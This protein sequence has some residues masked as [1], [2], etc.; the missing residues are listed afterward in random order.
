MIIL[1]AID[2]HDGSCVRLMQGDYATAQKVAESP[3]KAASYFE[4]EGAHW[5][6]MVDLDGAKFGRPVNDSC[7][8]DVL[9]QVNMKVELGGG[10]RDMQTVE[11]YLEKGV[12]RIILG[13]V[14]LKDPAFVREA[15]RKY[16][17]RIAVGI[18]AKGGK[19]AAEGWLQVSDVD[20]LDLAREMEQIGV[21]YIIFTDISKDGTMNGPDL[22]M[23]DRINREVSCNI[24][25]SGGVSN[26]KDILD[27]NALQLYGAICGKSIY[28]GSLSLKAAVRASQLISGIDKNNPEMIEDT[29]DLY[30]QKSELIPAVVQEAGTGDVLMLAYMNRQSLRKTLETGYTWFYSRSRQELWNK[31]A[32]SGHVQKVVSIT[33][34]CDDD[35]LLVKVVQ[36]GP[37]CHTRAHSCF[38]KQIWKNG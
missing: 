7:I 18:D 35:T 14:A 24:I 17:K 25:A 13:S 27:L 3:V 31:G 15:V 26:L 1:P 28:S 36:T 9:R 29:I 4:S 37:A 38:F 34:D 10:I 6:H 11:Y 30:F 8:F 23:L 20:Y 19:V 22:D 32:T 33:A 21:R 12:S 5:L 16:G 2:L